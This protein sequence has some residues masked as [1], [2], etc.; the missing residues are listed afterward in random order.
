[1]KTADDIEIDSCE[2]FL[3]RAN[4]NI[5]NE[6]L[7]RLLNVIK[8]FQDKFKTAHVGGSIGLMLHGIDL[9]RDLS[10]SDIDM[11]VDDY[12]PTD[13]PDGFIKSSNPNDFDHQYRININ[14][15]PA[16]RDTYIKMDI[17]VSPE[18]SYDVI[19]YNKINYRVSK[20]RDI[21]FWKRKYA[22]KGVQKHIDDLIVIDGGERPSNKNEMSTDDLPF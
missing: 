13:K 2:P 19:T 11:T 12:T 9:K 3:Y 20:L 15:D 21:I 16:L 18:P 10:N 14:N 4:I 8:S 6:Y 22:K 7:I 1:M 5:P 17:R